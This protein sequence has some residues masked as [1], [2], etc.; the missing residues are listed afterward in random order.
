MIESPFPR[1]FSFL[2]FLGISFFI[3]SFVS[4][5]F[6]FSSFFYFPFLAEVVALL[7]AQASLLKPSGNAKLISL[8]LCS[9]LHWD[10]RPA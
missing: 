2:H 9:A 4:L 6:L 10:Y 7:V 3:H 8:L 5:L 1:L